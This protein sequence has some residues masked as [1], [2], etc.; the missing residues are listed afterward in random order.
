MRWRPAATIQACRWPLPLPNCSNA[1]SRIFFLPDRRTLCESAEAAYIPCAQPLGKEV[2]QCL[3]V[4][5]CGLGTGFL[6]LAR[7]APE[8]G[9]HAVPEP[10]PTMERPP[11]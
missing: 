11:R 1:G 10:Q 6:P 5:I 7:I 8:E 4:I 2:I 3:I 9:V